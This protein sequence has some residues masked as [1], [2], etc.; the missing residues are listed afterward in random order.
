MISE[1]RRPISQRTSRYSAHFVLYVSANA[2]Y[3]S[4]GGE[5]CLR[6]MEDIFYVRGLMPCGGGH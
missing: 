4:C 5:S 2:I 3:S 1:K 6:D